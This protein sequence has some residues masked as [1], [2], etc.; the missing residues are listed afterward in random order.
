MS[1]QQHLPYLPAMFASCMLFQT[2]YVLCVAL[3]FAAPDLAGH[4]VLTTILPGF[5]LLTLASFIYGLVMS[6][7]YG[8]FVAATFVFFYNLWPSVASVIFGR[9][10]VTQ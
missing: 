7:F 2:L 6:M 4:T 5:Q 9:K 8:W 10:I 3:W 1:R